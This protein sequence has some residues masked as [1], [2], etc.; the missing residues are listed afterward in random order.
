MNRTM[1]RIWILLLILFVSLA[2]GGYILSDQ[3]FPLAEPICCPDPEKVT[4]VYL[5]PKGDSPMEAAGAEALLAAIAC[6]EPTRLWSVN[7]FPAAEE[8]YTLVLVTP[9]REYRYYLYE[10]DSRVYV[11]SPY[12]G[13]YQRDA[14]LLESIASY[15][16]E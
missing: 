3:M 14:R 5:S 4:A 16:S 12:E 9:E 11:E 7:E 6:A 1:K 15:I 13:V 10:E 8:Y 2:L